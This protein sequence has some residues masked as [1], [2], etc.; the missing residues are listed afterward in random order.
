MRPIPFILALTAALAVAASAG[1]ALPA[2]GSFAGTTSA[3][4]INGFQDVVMFKVL[5]GGRSLRQFQFSTL[6]CSGVGLIP[7]GVDPYALP[8]TQGTVPSITVSAKGLADYKGTVSFSDP[9]GVTTTAVIKAT[10]T[11]AT[12]VSGTISVSQSSNG[13]SPC[14]AALLKFSAS[15]GTPSSLGLS[16]T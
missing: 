8:Y 5:H 10:F 4:S 11:S 9:E 13:G 15:P 7:V 6:G 1:A 14:T 12:A 2:A 16:G 3:H